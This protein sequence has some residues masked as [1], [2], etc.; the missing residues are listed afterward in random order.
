M[1]VTF[2]AAARSRQA[3][4]SSRAI[5]QELPAMRTIMARED[6]QRVIPILG[7]AT[8]TGIQIRGSGELADL[9]QVQAKRV[10]LRQHAVQRRP[11]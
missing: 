8:F 11:V 2:P 10:D 7:L 5:S 4:R 9:Q 6:G 3:T 1:I